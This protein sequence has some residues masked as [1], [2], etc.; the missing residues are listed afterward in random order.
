MG[1]EIYILFMALSV[2]V[3]AIEVQHVDGVFPFEEAG[4]VINGVVFAPLLVTVNFPHLNNLAGVFQNMTLTSSSNMSLLP[5]QAFEDF[6]RRPAR[7]VSEMMDTLEAA[8][9]RARQDRDITAL[10]S[11]GLSGWALARTYSVENMVERVATQQEKLACVA[12]WTNAHIHQED[13]LINVISSSLNVLSMQ[14]HA[15]VALIG[16]YGYFGEAR[17]FERKFDSLHKGV[18]Q[19]LM[20]RL[21]TDLMPAGELEKAYNQLIQKA[22][23]AALR[24]VFQHWQQLL[25]TETSFHY[26]EGQL[27]AVAYVPLVSHEQEELSLWR[28][29]AVPW[30]FNQSLLIFRPRAEFLATDLRGKPKA[31]LPTSFLHGCKRHGAYHLCQ[32]PMALSTRRNLCLGH[33]FQEE[34]KEATNTCP[35]HYLPQEVSFHAINTTTM[36]VFAPEPTDLMESCPQQGAPRL[37]SVK[38][39]ALIRSGE[40]CAVESKGFFLSFGGETG[41]T[42]EVRLSVKLPEQLQVHGNWTFPHVNPMAE[43]PYARIHEILRGVETQDVEIMNQSASDRLSLV[44][45]VV[46]CIVGVLAVMAIVIVLAKKKCN[47][48]G[49]VSD[50][51]TEALSVNKPHAKLGVTMQELLQKRVEDFLVEQGW[52]NEAVDSETSVES[53]TPEDFRFES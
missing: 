6:G 47:A 39:L 40:H 2:T 23:K 22:A 13:K 3:R 15:L 1:K 18:Q 45:L 53:R 31:E 27:T 11:V 26:K 46:G 5:Q 30:T 33:L 34:I 21:T 36:L 43:T 38:G 24:P 52:A 42:E 4:A 8:Q 25:L 7:L 51:M 32:Q 44:L 19:L 35:I 17:Q 28:Y 16:E 37:A 41:P 20:G 49:A 48:K 50:L 10:V 29:Q 9:E 12:D 14:Q